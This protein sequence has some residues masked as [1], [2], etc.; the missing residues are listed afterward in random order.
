MIFTTSMPRRAADGRIPDWNAL[1]ERAAAQDGYLSLEQAGAAGYSP[2]LLQHYLRVGKLERSLRGVFRLVHFP[3]SDRE[4]LV[5]T[6]LWSKREG[7]FGLQTALVIHE[8]SDALPAR[9]YLI[10]PETWAKRR[11]QVPK[12][13]RLYIDDVP[14]PDW[15]WFGPVPVTTPLRTLRDCVKHH[16]PPDIVAQALAQAVQRKLIS[17]R[18]ARALE[19]DAA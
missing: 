6:W 13:V 5:P 19:R 12:I 2:Q 8:L 15:Q 7:V 9:H 16:M 17:R 10:V 11:V 14:R 18:E 1:Y 4:D 3:A